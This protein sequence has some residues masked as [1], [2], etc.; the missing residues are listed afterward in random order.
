MNIITKFTVATEQGMNVLLM[1]TRELAMEKFSSLIEQKII[2]NYI[3]EKFN[4]QTLINELNSM[5]NQWL[6]TYVDDN[7]AGY[8]RITSK[9]R[10]PSTL[11]GKRAIRI[12][13]FGIL[14][15]YTDPAVSNSLLEKCLN[16]CKPY[17]SI[18]INEYV[19][20][21][22]IKLF[23]NKGF[24]KQKESWQLDELALT[25]ACLIA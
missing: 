9:G 4:D 18:W 23:A 1:L 19:Q 22:V 13:D 8:A 11:D 17:E 6:V 16:V 12:A 21:P 20:N 5:S 7:P 15:K 25:S 14:K 10:R 3:S 2:D 24:I